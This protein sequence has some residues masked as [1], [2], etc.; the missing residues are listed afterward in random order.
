MPKRPSETH[1]GAPRRGRAA[2]MFLAS[3]LLDHRFEVYEPL[4]DVAIDLIAYNP[5]GNLL[6]IQSK[7][8]DP[9]AGTIHQIAL[10]RDP[11]ARLPTHVYLHRGGIPPEEWWLVPFNV[12]RKLALPSRTTAKGRDLVRLNLS[13]TTRKELLLYEKNHGVEAALDWA[14]G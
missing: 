1:A 11:R 3:L 9:D 14:P 8:R 13:A 6:A 2:E 5:R 7:Q 4:V 12:F 10:P